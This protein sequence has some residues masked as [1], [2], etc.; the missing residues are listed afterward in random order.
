MSN[1]NKMGLIKPEHL[2]QNDRKRL[3]LV[4]VLVVINLILT[5][6]AVGLLLLG[7][8]NAGFY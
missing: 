8:G 5:A 6:S 3:T 1:T 7:G 4:T 2:S